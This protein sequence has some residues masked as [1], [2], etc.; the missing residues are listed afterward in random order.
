MNFIISLLFFLLFSF[1][2]QAFAE[3]VYF[4]TL[5]WP[6]FTGQEL[7]DQGIFALIAKKAFKAMG[8]ELVLEFYPWSRATK[9]GQND[10][11]YAGYFPKY[12]D[13]D[14]ANNFLFSDPI[15][16]SIIGFV[17][18]K[19]K[20]IVWNDLNDLKPYR[21]G[22]VRGYTNT[23]QID[24]MFSKHQ[25]NEKPAVSDL[26]NLKK[27]MANHLDMAIIDKTVLEYLLH[28]NKD[29]SKLKKQ[30][31]FNQRTLENKEIS[32]CFKKTSEGKKWHKIFNEGLKMVNIKKVT[33]EYINSFLKPKAAL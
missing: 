30:F 33:Q 12:Y 5:E 6:P 15:G 10:P 7:K 27:L 26:I 28:T 22:T 20:P 11:K 23:E 9:L 3:R 14:L 16:S 25:L 13:K 17:E 31:H 19:S 4:A 1:S 32:L 29:L 18:L 8:H 24:E 2:N 21:I